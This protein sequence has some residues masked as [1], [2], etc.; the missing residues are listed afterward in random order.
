MTSKKIAFEV[1]GHRGARARWPENTLESIQ[2]ALDAG[3]DAV[4][5]DVLLSRD[6]VALLVHDRALNTTL[7]R[8]AEGHAP[9]DT[10][11]RQLVKDF[12]AAE[13]A[14]LDV[15]SV[16]HP[17]FPTQQARP[18][19]RIPT[20]DAFAALMMSHPRAPTLNIEIKTHPFLTEETDSP[21]DFA[22][23]ILRVLAHHRVP[24]SRVLFQS[25]DPA[26]ILA[27]KARNPQWRASFLVDAWSEDIPEVAH[28][29]GVQAVSPRFDL[30]S[31]E[32][33]SALHNAGLDI[34]VWTPNTADDWR[35]MAALGVKGIITDDPAACLALRASL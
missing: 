3:V 16:Q 25:F 20:L 4:E 10:Q 11:L 32:R 30:L 7:Y 21:D 15:G 13:L 8:W 19:A 33:A 31:A 9:I 29:L 35:R 6:K 24:P 5:I 12:T 26:A 27:L 28:E 17:D 18:G 2:G 23:A 34:Y 1:H 22:E 14:Q